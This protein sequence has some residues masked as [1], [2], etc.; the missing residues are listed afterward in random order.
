MAF[1]MAFSSIIINIFY[2]LIIIFMHP[3]VIGQWTEYIYLDIY[4][5]KTYWM[6]SFSSWQLKPHV[7]YSFMYYCMGYDWNTF[8]WYEESKLISASF[9][10]LHI[11]PCSQTWRC[12]S[13][14]TDM[15]KYF[16]L[17]RVKGN[18]FYLILWSH[19]VLL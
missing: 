12:A 16:L 14:S 5:R 9:I 15:E 3:N 7:I 18:F 1:T 13:V 11:Y 2:V 17:E 6:H 4:N 8:D 10:Y 19:S